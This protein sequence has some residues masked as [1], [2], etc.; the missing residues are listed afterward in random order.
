VILK[1]QKLIPQF[2]YLCKKKMNC[3]LCNC[4]ETSYRINACEKEFY[5][6]NNC[7]LIF[8]GENYRLDRDTEKTRYSFHQ[9]NIQDEGYV[10][11]LNQIILPAIDLIKPGSIGLDFGCGPNPVLAKLIEKNGF[12]CDYY[13]PFF[14][15]E[16]DLN[17]KYDFIFATECFEHF[18]SPATEL[19]KICN[20]L[21]PG[22]ILAVMTEIRPEIDKF[23]DWYYIKDPTHVCFY[24]NQSFD[25][26]CEKY[27]LKIA[28]WDGKRVVVM[29]KF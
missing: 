26:I 8:I 28:F 19:E 11:F 16:I 12:C 9:N 21:N 3:P 27:G 22:G 14:F 7:G 18:F 4:C 15:P 1:I 5:L 17:K 2:S 29:R 10:G 23:R 24:S 6:C 25:F 13:D 20:M